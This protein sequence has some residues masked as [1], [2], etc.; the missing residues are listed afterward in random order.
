MWAGAEGI[1]ALAHREHGP[2][3]MAGALV[4]SD[5]ALS[6]RQLVQSFAKKK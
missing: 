5:F 3:A 1:Y 4:L 6:V 2:E